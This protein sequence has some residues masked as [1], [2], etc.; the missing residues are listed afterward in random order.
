MR[1]RAGRQRRAGL[2]DQTA[3]IGV[4]REILAGQHLAGSDPRQLAWKIDKPRRRRDQLARGDV[5]GGKREA[6][7]GAF[8]V[9][10]AKQ[11]GEKIVRAGVEQRLFGERAG[12]NEPHHVTAHHRFRPA[13]LGL[14]RIL[15]LLAHGHAMPLGDQALKIVVG[16]VHRHAAHGDVLPEMLAALGERDAERAGSDRRVVE[17]HLVEIAHAVEQ[18]TVGVVRL[19]LQI[20]GHHRCRVRRRRGRGPAGPW[21]CRILGHA[22]HVTSPRAFSSR[23]V[24]SGLI[25]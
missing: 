13:L 14:G 2:A 15:G 5:D 23:A 4:A 19:D 9:A 16:R 7:L 21:R 10:A 12:G 18:Q 3:K 6:R 20:L 17:E 24:T 22:H 1:A 8:L 25:P 11:S